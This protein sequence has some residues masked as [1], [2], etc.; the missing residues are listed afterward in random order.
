MWALL[1]PRERRHRIGSVAAMPALSPIWSGDGLL[2]A[3]REQAAVFCVDGSREGR[4]RWRA[5][6]G[7]RIA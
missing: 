7:R 6:A 5:E 4:I 2:T 1:M 3:P